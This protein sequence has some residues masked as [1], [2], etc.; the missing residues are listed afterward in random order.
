MWEDFFIGEKIRGSKYLR[1]RSRDG[2]GVEV[3]W[4]EDKI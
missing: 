1:E 2:G 3:K 4:K